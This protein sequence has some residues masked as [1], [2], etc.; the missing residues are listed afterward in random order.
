MSNVTK[1]S[2]DIFLQTI[3]EELHDEI[4]EEIELQL[5][6]D[7]SDYEYYKFNLNGA[8]YMIPKTDLEYLVVALSMQ[9]LESEAKLYLQSLGILMT[10]KV[11]YSVYRDLGATEE[12]EECSKKLIDLLED[13]LQNNC[14]PSSQK[15]LINFLL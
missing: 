8:V 14:L 12:D 3:P 1:I 7:C 11:L 4:A 6:N 9:E 10:L 2:K 15:E 5:P 13:C